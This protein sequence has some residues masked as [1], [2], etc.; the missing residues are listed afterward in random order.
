MIKNILKFIKNIF[1]PKAKEGQCLTLAEIFKITEADQEIIDMLAAECDRH[2]ERHARVYGNWAMIPNISYG[3]AEK[4]PPFFNSLVTKTTEAYLNRSLTQRLKAMISHD[5]ERQ[6]CEWEER[7][8][9]KMKC[10]TL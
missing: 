3:I 2:A 7:Y 8:R 6:Q 5:K 4:R 10:V 1:K 9:E